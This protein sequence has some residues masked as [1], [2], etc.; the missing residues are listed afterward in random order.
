[1]TAVGNYI[2]LI[3]VEDDTVTAYFSQVVCDLAIF[4]TYS[5]IYLW[6]SNKYIFIIY[7]IYYIHLQD[8]M[9]LVNWCKKPTFI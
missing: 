7:N 1:M 9:I 6:I 2:D 3:Q 4:I 5:H 8:N